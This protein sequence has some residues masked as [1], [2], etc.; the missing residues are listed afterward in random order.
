MGAL[1]FPSLLSCGL[2]VVGCSLIAWNCSRFNGAVQQPRM[3]ELDFLP[4][5]VAAR[6][7]SVGHPTTAAKLRWIDSFSFFQ[8]QLAH[9]G[10]QDEQNGAA[11]FGHLYDMLIGMD[12]R[13]LPYYEH[14]SLCLG[15]VLQQNHAVQQVLN[16]GL[17]EL[18]HETS[19]WRML[20]AELVVNSKVEQR[21]PRLF[22][23]FLGAWA[24]A[25]TSEEDRQAVFIWKRNIALRNSLGL[26][27]IAYWE[28]QLRRSSPGSPSRDFIIDTIREMLAQG[29]IEQLEV[30]R[31]RWIATRFIPPVL[32]GDLAEPGLIR[33]CFPHGLPPLA[34]LRLEQGR[35]AIA[36]DPFGY[37]YRLGNQGIESPGLALF[38]ARSRAATHSRTLESLAK[39]N[40]SWPE[41]FAEATAAGLRLEDPPPGARWTLI[42]HA[43]GIELPPA[44]FPPWEPRPFK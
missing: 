11:G 9:R 21:N 6:L 25:E 26:S 28:E 36:P 2:V 31:R 19:L 33:E 12:P 30:L 34:P 7:L 14:A 27:Q 20:A 16:R 1:R 3:K 38:K 23:A 10:E 41:T 32:I 24:G 5:P 40:G 42:D 39:K 22:D 35:P 17:M 15:G 4:S 8:W 29:G 44:P 43:I 13:F 18:P 37:P